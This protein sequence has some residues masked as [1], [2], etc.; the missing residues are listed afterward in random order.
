AGGNLILADEAALLEHRLER[1]KPD[2]VV[3]HRQIFGRIAVLAGEARLVDVPA[4]RHAHGE[5][6]GEGA[7]LPFG[8]KHRLVRLRLDRAEAMHAAHVLRAVH[9]SPAVIPGR[10]KGASPES[11]S[12]LGACIWIPD[13]LASL[14]VRNDHMK[15]ISHPRA[16]SPARCR[17]WNRASPARPGAPRSSPRCRPA[18]SE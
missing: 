5:G 13:R 12:R 11:G 2:L 1:G 6:Q 16:A 7:L 3:A 9:L 17:S 14:G 8:M 10:T 4:A 18:A 15:F